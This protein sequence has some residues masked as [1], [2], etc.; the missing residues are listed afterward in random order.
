MTQVC[1]DQTPTN[2]FKKWIA[3]EYPS[4]AKDFEVL[5]SGQR[6]MIIEDYVRTTGRKAKNKLLSM[7][8]TGRYN[9][10]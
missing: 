10:G 2:H 6:A 4:F 9:E 1:Q 7:H 3:V 8:T 5:S